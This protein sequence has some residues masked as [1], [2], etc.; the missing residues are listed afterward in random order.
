MQTMFTSTVWEVKW[1]GSYCMKKASAALLPPFLLG[2][3]R[4]LN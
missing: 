1:K 4:Q 3:T 2:D